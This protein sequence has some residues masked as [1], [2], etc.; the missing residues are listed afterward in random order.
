MKTF[1]RRIALASLV[2][3]SAGACAV[4]GEQKDKPELG[5][6]EQAIAMPAP[7]WGG[8]ESLG[9]STSKNATIATN[10]TNVYAFIVDDSG[11][12][13]V[14]GAPIGSRN[15][16]TGWRALGDNSAGPVSV[17]RQGRMLGVVYR[18]A[19]DN[20]LHAVFGSSTWTAPV[21]LGGVLA[22]DP[23]AVTVQDVWSGPMIDVYSKGMDGVLRHDIASWFDP[24]IPS[25]WSDWQYVGTQ[26]SGMPDIGDLSLVSVDGKREDVVFHANFD[27]VHVSRSDTTQPFT[28]EVVHNGYLQRVSAA[29][30]GPGHLDVVWQD[31]SG[32]TY[33]QA[34]VA[35]V[36]QSSTPLGGEAFHRVFE[37]RPKVAALNGTLQYVTVGTNYLVYGEGGPESTPM[38]AW[39]PIGSGCS[40]YRSEP[41]LVATDSNVLDMLVVGADHAVY[42]ATF[43][44]YPLSS[45]DLPACGCGAIGQECCGNSVNGT[46]CSAP[47]SSAIC[48]S[49]NEC[50]AC[51]KPG[52]PCCLGTPDQPDGCASGAAC[53]N[54][55]MGPVCQ[56]CG[57]QGQACCLFGES[58]GTGLTCTTFCEA[59]GWLGEPCLPGN[60]CQGDLFCALGTCHSPAACGEAMQVCCADGSCKPGAG[61]CVGGTCQLPPPQPPP[62]PPPSPSCYPYTKTVCSGGGSV[63]ANYAVTDEICDATCGS[64][65]TFANEW[66]LVEYVNVAQNGTIQIC[67]DQP[68]PSGWTTI[69]TT[70][71]PGHC[72]NGGQKTTTIKRT[73]SPSSCAMP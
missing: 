52:Q 65:S 70:D 51:G 25:D 27:L 29:S 28:W 12:L 1:I 4:A 38:N 32:N 19:G 55:T 47:K 16:W 3:G 14:N 59:K 35:G 40:E 67:A 18:H 50:E 58:C 34:Q 44:P 17:A 39:L 69:T 2:A 66:A 45:T 71:A 20:H 54:T 43:A 49:W 24:W 46:G 13:L 9:G 41:S 63:P 53:T 26:P 5:A 73:T 64:C 68:V 72:I 37:A 15:A 23:V 30:I 57:G 6:E 62:P 10:G 56:S 60:V 7:H 11:N 42:H 61:S 36:W 8:W 21:D 48:S 33:S 22:L 31:A